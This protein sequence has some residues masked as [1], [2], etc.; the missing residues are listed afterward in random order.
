MQVVHWVQLFVRCWRGA[1][2][3]GRVHRVPC[4][5]VEALL[6]V[7]RA[8]LCVV[9][10]AHQ[11]LRTVLPNAGWE[12]PLPCSSLAASCEVEGA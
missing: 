10:R 12:V 7:R 2:T 8:V 9:Q 1:A 11:P 6:H 3:A 5:S 4:L